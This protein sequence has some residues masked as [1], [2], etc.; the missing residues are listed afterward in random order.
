M[1]YQPLIVGA[2]RT[3]ARKKKEKSKDFVTLPTF[4][5]VGRVIF[6][7]C[8]PLH[9]LTVDAHMTV[10]VVC[11]R[12]IS[13]EERRFRRRSRWLRTTGYSG[14][15]AMRFHGSLQHTDQIK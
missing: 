3:R 6:P 5:A 8:R 12:P 9:T 11:E 1:R 7:V 14:R 15:L 2:E 4:D 13:K 10:V